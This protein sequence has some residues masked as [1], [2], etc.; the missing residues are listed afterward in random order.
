MLIN[1]HSINEIKY[2]TYKKYKIWLSFSFP[3]KLSNCKFRSD[4]IDFKQRLYL[5]NSNYIIAYITN[6][7][8]LQFQ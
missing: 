2:P 1:N 5:I 7:Y 3:N 4:L 8:K 6:I